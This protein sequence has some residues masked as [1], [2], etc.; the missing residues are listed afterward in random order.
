MVG[1]GMLGVVVEL[2]GIVDAAGVVG[3]GVA[4]VVVVAFSGGVGGAT[5]TAVAMVIQQ[6]ALTG[7]G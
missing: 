3:V 7:N 1:V 6:L 2:V 4:C 5:L